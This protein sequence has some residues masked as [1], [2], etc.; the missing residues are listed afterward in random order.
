VVA[1]GQPAD[2][3]PAV[4]VQARHGGL[5]GLLSDWIALLWSDA[6]H[7]DALPLPHSAS[8]TAAIR[9]CSTDARAVVASARSGLRSLAGRL[10]TLHAALPPGLEARAGGDADALTLTAVPGATVPATAASPAAAAAAAA[11]TPEPAAGPRAA[12]STSLSPARAT[13]AAPAVAAVS[14]GP[15]AVPAPPATPPRAPAGSARSG[16]PASAASASAS[17]ATSRLRPAT[18]DATQ[19]AVHH[20]SPLRP[21]SPPA[22]AGVGEGGSS[23]PAAGECSATPARRA[24]R[25]VAQ[26][27][28]SSGP[29]AAHLSAVD[30]VAAM[31]AAASS[32]A[33]TGHK[34]PRG[35]SFGTDGSPARAAGAGV[36]DAADPI[37]EA[38]PTG[39]PRRDDSGMGRDSIEDSPRD[40]LGAGTARGKSAAPSVSADSGAGA[41]AAAAEGGAGRTGQVA[42]RPV[43]CILS[44][45]GHAG[46]P[47]RMPP[48]RLAFATPPPP[49]PPATAPASVI[50]AGP[51]AGSSGDA[52]SA[53]AAKRRRTMLEAD[54][55]GDDDGGAA[56]PEGLDASAGLLPRDLTQAGGGSVEGGAPAV[57][58]GLPVADLSS[59]AYVDVR[60]TLACQSDAQVVELLRM[61]GMKSGGSAAS[62]RSR[63]LWAAVN[64]CLPRCPKCSNGYLVWRPAADAAADAAAPAPAPAG[65]GA[66]AGHFVCAGAFDKAL[67]RPV[68]CD[69]AR[70]AEEV[71]RRAWRWR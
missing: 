63:A 19:P 4:T 50:A 37:S 17:P 70:A 8:V 66:G 10:E 71:G 9:R 62:A 38:R 28:T 25:P 5:H 67:R 6:A 43:P 47:V 68:P 12:R 26:V 64:G 27:L 61:N 55:D 14:S 2:G 48:S 31:S 3:G 44:D 42:L 46:T 58:W 52:A 13:Q 33:L 39:T 57:V 60:H 36:R 32:L 54:H 53:V 41:A 21:L 40:R 20:S 30:A 56:A 22:T 15:A 35:V 65:A 16:T 18:L 51:G 7:A 34:R 24:P 59:P 11:A 45:G 69:F 29:V 49:P 1:A 23:L